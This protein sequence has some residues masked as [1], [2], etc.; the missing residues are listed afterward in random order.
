MLKAKIH[1]AIVT[2]ADLRYEG[3]ITLDRDL[4][5]ATGIAKYEE[6]HIWDV[7]AGHRLITYAIEGPRGSGTVA[8]NGAAAHLVRRGHRVIVGCFA[9]FEEEELCQHEARKVFVDDQN[10]IVNIERCPYESSGM[11]RT[12]T[13]REHVTSAR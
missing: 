10:R 7:T 3:S 12:L 6:V 8:I 9:S 1:N 11:V 2:D 4:M 13:S 5:D